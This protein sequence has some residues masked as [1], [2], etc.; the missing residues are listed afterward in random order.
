MTDYAP[1]PLEFQMA[2]EAGRGTLTAMSGDRRAGVLAFSRLSDD[3]LLVEHVQTFPG[4]QGQG[5]GQRI[6]EEGIAWARA[7]AHKL[8]PLCPFARTIFD[9]HPEYADVRHGL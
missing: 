5:V 9:R 4:F 1:I 6:V 8:M 2:E 7:N 3:T